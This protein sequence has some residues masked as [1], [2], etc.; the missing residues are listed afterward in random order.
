ME[1]SRDRNNTQPTDLTAVEALMRTIATDHLVA[2]DQ[3]GQAITE[4][5]AAGGKRIRASM[6]LSAGTCLGLDPQTRRALAACSELLHN[7]S[8]I[9]DD[10]QDADAERRAHPALWV[11][12]G[13]DLAIC[14]GDSLISAAY[15]VLAQIS[16]PQ[17]I[18]PLMTLTHQAVSRTIAGQTADLAQTGQALDDITLYETI[19]GE[20]SG[21]LLGLPVTL[22]LSVA[23]ALDDIRTV[24]ATVRLIAIAY[25][26]VD[27]IGDW[28]EDQAQGSLNG[29]LVLSRAQNIAP[30]AAITEAATLTRQHL[31]HARTQAAKLPQGCGKVF[32]DLADRLDAKLE[33]ELALAT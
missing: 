15:A 19:A 3:I 24:E 27:D 11:T 2:D 12:H 10:I 9:H 13:T 1:N 26:F 33:K 31:M 21:P 32:V 17:L 23:G 8:L 14:A 4:H 25:Q 5:F 6:A 30:E 7:A 16:N 29:V 18:A 20:K 22:S 28:E